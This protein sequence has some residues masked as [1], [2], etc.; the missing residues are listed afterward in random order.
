MI[1]YIR[2]AK[3]QW[4]CLIQEGK[5][6]VESQQGGLEADAVVKTSHPIYDVNGPFFDAITYLKGSSVLRMIR[7]VIG[8]ENFQKA[9]QEYIKMYKFSNADHQML[10]ERF[11]AASKH[12]RYDWCG[13]Q[14]DATLFLNP[15]F[16]QQVII[17]SDSF[18][19]LCW[20]FWTRF[21]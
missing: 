11:T 2:S 8:P 3:M 15:W 6:L 5:F 1:V 10:F 18:R 4:K 12:N 16:L 7:A 19:Y 17:T 13:R 14:L 9:L 20:I 21:W